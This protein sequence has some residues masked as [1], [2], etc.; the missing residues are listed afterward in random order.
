VITLTLISVDLLFAI[1]LLLIWKN[2][3]VGNY[4]KIYTAESEKTK[5]ENR[6]ET[7]VNGVKDMA[8]FILD[9]EG[10]ITSW[11]E[12]AGIIV[13]YKSDEIIGR[14]YSV[15]YPAGEIESQTPD[16][17]LQYAAA[18]G[19]F[20]GEGWRN[21]KDGS[22]FWASVLINSLKDHNENIYGYLKIIRDLTERKRI[23][24]EIRNSRDFYL[25]LFND[26]PTPIWR[27]DLNGKVNYFNRAWLNYTGKSLTDELNGGWIENLH[28]DEKGNILKVYN[29]A[30]GNKTN[31]MIE[32]RLKNNLGSF[33]WFINYGIPY[34]DA[35]NKFAGY[36]GS[37]FDI[38]DRKNYEESINAL[39]RIGEKLYSSLEINQILDL[40]VT[41]CIEIAAADGGYACVKHENEYIVS[42]YF[43]KDHW[44]YYDAHY[45]A[46][47]NIIGRFNRGKDPLII[48]NK[49]D[50]KT[51]GD[52][53][54]SKYSVGCSI[55]LPLFG[56]GG[57]LL[58]FFE[59]H[60]SDESKDIKKDILNLLK[61]VARNASV[62]ISK[63]MNYE[64]LRVTESQLRKSEA[65]LRNLAAQIQ[66]G[67][68]EE[69][70]RIARELHDE[71]GQLFT[72]INLSISLLTEQMEVNQP[73][74]IGE[75]VEE[76]Y[77]V[78]KYVNKG[79]QS[80]RD[81]SANLRSYVLDHLGLIPALQEYCR[82][83][84]RMSGI[85]CNF[86]SD[87]D[88]VKMND[89]KSTALFRIV[90]EGITNVLRHA[91][92][93]S[94]WVGVSL[95]DA[96]LEITIA[97]NGKGISEN[98]M[99]NTKSIGLLGM[100]ERAIFIN[101]QLL[102]ESTKDQGTVIRLTVPYS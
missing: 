19:S 87:I 31:I 95:L 52:N 12:G 73:P 80:V 43:N 24:E 65:E 53:I 83:I 15:L 36:L 100:K 26:F 68:E 101:G 40:L 44:E 81:I 47:D 91:E 4:K 33:R 61:A 8:I 102:I 77:S 97:D 90:Q 21:R 63:A 98:E 50:N 16:K 41:E 7:L 30:F 66:Y 54:I 17:N 23:E 10:V 86:K 35:E 99:S 85:K 69:R 64:Q 28:P 74:S 76:L 20:L 6:F 56:S 42:R 60:F 46:D 38:E 93:T 72:G 18:N 3:I 51:A 82:E 11:N 78:Q 48:S 59:I 2:T 29:D 14:H 89:E 5:L 75:I 55:A 9:K 79:I 70:Q 92:A 67:R 13:G 62:S 71:L 49:K 32:F 94:I 58:G 39:L 27:S 88:S 34:Y 57:D 25:K 37:C 84:E 1:V 45:P 22:V 96:G